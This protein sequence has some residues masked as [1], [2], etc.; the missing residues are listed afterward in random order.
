MVPKPSG[1]KPGSLKPAPTVPP[2][3]SEPNPQRYDAYGNPIVEGIQNVFIP[4]MGWS[5]DLY[6]R[7]EIPNQVRDFSGSSRDGHPRHSN[8]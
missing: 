7:D 5:S 6:R 4:G 3:V 2:K 1:P 8:Y